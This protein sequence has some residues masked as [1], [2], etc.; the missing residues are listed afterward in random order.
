MN[1]FSDLTD[2]EYKNMLG[3]HSDKKS[4]IFRHLNYDLPKTHKRE[5]NWVVDGA[6][7]DVKD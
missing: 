4:S 2:F 1:K 6:V 7:T 5:V 3:Y